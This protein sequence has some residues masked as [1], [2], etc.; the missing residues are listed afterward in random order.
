MFNREGKLISFSLILATAER[1][2][3]LERF[4]ASL[5]A[6]TY[7]DFELIVVDQ[8]KDDR[9]APILALYEGRFS[10]LHFRSEP[11]RTR[12]NNLGLTRASN[13]VIG[14][15]D[16]DCRF[17]QDLLYRVAQFF[18]EYPRVDGLTG[19]SVDDND[20]DS[21]G[22][23][24]HEA[25]VVDKFNAWYRS[26]AYTI[27]VRREATRGVWFDEEMGP[28]AKTVWGA[29][30]DHDYLLKVLSR[31]ALI[32]YDPEVR[33]LHPEPAT[34]FDAAAAHRAYTYNCGAGRAIR[35]HNFPWRFKAWWLVRPLGGL[36]LRFFRIKGP[37][38]LRIAGRSSRAD[39]EGC[40]VNE[41][42]VCEAKVC[43]KL[44]TALTLRQFES[45]SKAP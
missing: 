30:E 36:V 18:S 19:R 21:N 33:V 28:G 4:L 15:P 34:V 3:E 31:G 26:T 6:Q 17:P 44:S 43:G 16:D 9:L 12:A 23:W 20:R 7:R 2:H 1:T 29:G 5:D 8:N 13:N 32:F 11:G 42:E 14:F 38:G 27:F 45:L 41:R 40:V 10:I 35:R 25:G 24:H 39:G 37:P 22:T